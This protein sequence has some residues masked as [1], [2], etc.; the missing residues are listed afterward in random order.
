MS[1][2]AVYGDWEFSATSLAARSYLYA[3]APIG[4]GTAAVESLTGYI[5]RLAA[6]H[7]V[8]TGALVNHELLPRIPYTKGMAVGQ[9]PS[10]LPGYSFYID[11][12]SLNGVADRARLW[13]SLLE[14]LTCIQRLDV[15][16][17]LPWAAAISCVHL[18]RTDRAWCALC[19]GAESSSAPSAYERL[20]WA[21]KIVRVC[22][23][24]RRQLESLCPCC[25]RTQY[26]FSPRSRPGYC[27]RCHCWL[28]RARETR[29]SDDC[30][31][32]QLQ[33]AQM[34]GAL[35]A[36]SPS[37]PT[38]FGLD[39]FQGN[40]R[41]CVSHDRR[42]L[43]SGPAFRNGHVRHWMRGAN[44]PRMDYLAAFCRRHAVS[45]LGLLTAT[46]PISCTRS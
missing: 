46:T 31:T 1:D 13:V 18:L 11:A 43:E 28:G 7:A 35:L 6:A 38:R 2:A 37:L 30:L 3:P 21:F 41:Y 34:V 4:I 5:A 23:V 22:P 20:S 16:T 42:K 39:R 33:I 29:A 12:Y 15:L 19:Y 25:G 36:A 8:E 24:H 40:V 32:E 14:R 17:A 44:A 9:A 10:T 26:V 45:M 27:S